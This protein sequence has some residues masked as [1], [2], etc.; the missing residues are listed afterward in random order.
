[1]RG[2]ELIR[3]VLAGFAASVA[4]TGSLGFV[5]CGPE[6]EEDETASENPGEAAQDEMM[7]DAI[8]DSD[9]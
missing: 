9:R 3:G 4:L 8:R 2:Y 5:T 6:V 7:D 1:M